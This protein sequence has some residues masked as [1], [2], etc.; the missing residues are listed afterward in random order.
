[1][2]SPKRKRYP[3]A[4]HT[5]WEP[6]DLLNLGDLIERWEH[7][8]FKNTEFS[9]IEKVKTILQGHCF[10]TIE[11]K[12]IVHMTLLLASKSFLRSCKT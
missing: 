3:N 5:F 9:N 11:E 4:N 1:V 8:T 12:Q 2:P 10:P 6:V 7:H